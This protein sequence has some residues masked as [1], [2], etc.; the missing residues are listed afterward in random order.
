VIDPHIDSLLCIQFGY[1][2]D[3][4]QIVVDCSS[5]DI[6]IYKEYLEN[7]YLIFHNAKFDLQ[8]LFNLNI[9]PRKIYDTM[10]VEQL[11]YL[12]FS[13]SNMS[14]SHYDK[15]EYDFPY[16]YIDDF[17]NLTLSYSLQSLVDKYC[18][19]YLDKTIRGQ[20]I[21]RGL[22]MQ[23]ILYAAKDVVFLED[24]MHKQIEAC[25]NKQCIQGAI[26]EC[27]SVPA[28]SYM[29]WCGIM[30]DES[31]WK[32]KMEKDKNNLEQRK[33]ALDNFIITNPLLSKYYKLDL[34]GDLFEGFKDTPE[35]LIN[36][37]SSK[38]VIDLAKTLGFDTKTQDKKTGEDKDSVLEKHLKNQ[39]GINDEFLNLY[40]DYKESS[41]VVST[42]GESQLNMINPNTGRCHT[43]YKQLGASSSRMSCG[44]TNPNESLAKLKGIPKN[45]CT[46]CNFQQLPSDHD[47]RSSF[48]APEGYKMVS[49]DFAAEEARLGGDIYKDEAILKM[50]REG[51]DSHSMYAKIF[52]KE[53]LK[54]VDVNDIKKLRPDLRQMAKGPEFA[55]NFGGGAN[56]IMQAIQC[57][58]EEA[59]TIIKNYEEGFRG[60]VE[61]AK[62]GSKLV[63]Q[64]GYVLINPIT[65]HK[66]Y[67][68]DHKEW[69]ER[70]KTFTSEFWED[71][72]NNHKGK[73]TPI[74]L[75]VKTHFKAASKW[76]RMARNA[77]CQGTAA[78]IMKTCLTNLFNWI[79][80]NSY[81]GRINICASVHDEIV[82]DYPK[83]IEE[84]PKILVNIM[85]TAAAK[86]CK[87]LPIPAEASVGDFWIH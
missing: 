12:G 51:I 11:L 31:K 79:V 48:V 53:Q 62:K 71:Y 2:K 87:S 16:T 17:N 40:F 32:L 55:L 82:C 23:T 57:T 10:I 13:Y 34:Q 61:F 66:M 28:I 19:T 42:Y 52:F 67:W 83:E 69:L 45:S 15:Y 47:T 65:G 35:C 81:F 3:D 84:F 50:F 8:F 37:D 46:Y 85:E 39:K 22:D 75:L 6:S 25:R 1:N 70:Q 7:V 86:Y 41:K 9:I 24:I 26:L 73:G 59:N 4:I 38:Q 60:T 14:K 72:R 44:S 43:T 78:I 74:A 56:A 80:D 63:R 68:W 49:A 77:P 76:D 36:W 58:E 64:N 20:I 33:Q 54:D 5:I 18:N 30:L 21:W 29:E 27:L